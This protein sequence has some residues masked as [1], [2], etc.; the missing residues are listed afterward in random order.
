M[1]ERRASRRFNQVRQLAHRVLFDFHDEIANTPGTVKARGMIVETALEYLNSLAGDATGDPGLQWEL[2]VA[3]AKVAA[4][5]GAVAS[6]SLGRPREAAASYEKALR[7]ARPLAAANRLDRGQ[8]EV[9]AGILCDAGEISRFL[10][11]YDTALR[12]DREADAASTGLPAIVRERVLAETATTLNRMGDLLG[13][14]RAL[15]QTLAVSRENATLNPSWENWQQVVTILTDLGVARHRL[16]RYA[17]GQAAEAEAL[18]ILRS[19]AVHRPDTPRTTRLVTRALTRMGDVVGACDRPSLEKFREAAARYGEAMVMAEKLMRED[20]NDLSS[21]TDAGILLNKS[22]C[23]LS[24]VD[25]RKA[26]VFGTRATQLFDTA[27]PASNQYRAQSRIANANAL[28][29]LGDF[30]SAERL[31][32]EA[33]GLILPNDLN[34]RAD[35]DLV[36]ARMEAARGNREAAARW[37][38]SAIQADTTLFERTATPFY[39]WNLARVLEFAAIALPESAQRNRELIVN[40]WHDQNSRFPGQPYIEQQVA[41]AEKRFEGR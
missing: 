26:L 5:Q 15:E 14:V 8:R 38:A 35:L 37:F 24:E 18:A 10:R 36:W 7:L 39:A 19:P 29:E 22:A 32:K 16:T 17:E 33:D 11:D 1:Q 2:A 28:R 30:A 40:V 41:E 23:V 20:P 4:A 12:L 6:P 25:P 3:Y 34:T 21:R 13:S 27:V 31:L 9:L